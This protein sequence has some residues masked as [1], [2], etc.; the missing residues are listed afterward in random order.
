MDLITAV[1]RQRAQGGSDMKCTIPI[2]KH[3]D[4][5]VYYETIKGGEPRFIQCPQSFLGVNPPLS[6]AA[7]GY[8]ATYGYEL[9]EVLDYGEFV[10]RL[11]KLK[12]KI[13]EG[14]CI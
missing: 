7:I 6:K 11:Y 13:H 2:T 10:Y 14:I 4:E 12:G 3:V 5:F 1:R 9:K 8:F